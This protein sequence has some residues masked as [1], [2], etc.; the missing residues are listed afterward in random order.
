M[1]PVQ[2]TVTKFTVDVVFSLV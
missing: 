1:N 2:F